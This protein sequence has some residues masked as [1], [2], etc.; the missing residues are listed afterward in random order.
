[1]PLDPVPVEDGN[2]WVDGYKGST[3]VV[4]VAL[5][6]A[7]VPPHIALRYVS[8]FV[9]CPHADQWRNE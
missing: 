4:E 8:H 9:T 7:T 3:P 5:T 6:S 2:V 1:M